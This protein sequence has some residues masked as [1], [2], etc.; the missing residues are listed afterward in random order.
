MCVDFVLVQES[1]FV[2][3]R[4]ES[5]TAPASEKCQ[6]ICHTNLLYVGNVNI[7]LTIRWR[8]FEVSL[9][10]AGIIVTFL[11]FGFLCVG[12]Y[13]MGYKDTAPDEKREK[14]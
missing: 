9:S 13:D 4:F 5:S 3:K 12:Q 6:G 10:Q 11:L 7:Q 8:L 1:P 2:S 14:K